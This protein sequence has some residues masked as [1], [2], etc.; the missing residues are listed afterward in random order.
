M[1]RINCLR[2]SRKM[3]Q[4]EFAEIFNVDQTAVSNWENDK[5]NIDIKILESIA[6][7][8][9][10]PI[11]FVLGNSF[12]LRIPT[13]AWSEDEIEELEIA[14]KKGYGDLVLFKTGVGYFSNSE[15]QKEKPTEDGELSENRR[16]L[17][18][19]ARTVPEDKVDSVLQALQSILAILK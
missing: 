2:K 4:S 17:I 18:E 6:Y 8:F 15:P 13:T 9:K 14:T 19:W 5:N 1:N 16:K 10:V 7:Y 3:S 12:S 11:E